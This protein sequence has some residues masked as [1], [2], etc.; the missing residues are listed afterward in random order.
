[1]ILSENYRKNGETMVYTKDKGHITVA[2]VMMGLS[3]TP[4]CSNSTL[5]KEAIDI[6]DKNR[7]GIICISDSSN[8]LEGIITDGDIRRIL[9]RVQKP[10]AAILGDDVVSYAIKN[11]ITV[12]LDTLLIDAVS[13]MG[14]KK[15]WDLPI[16]DNKNGK[17][18]GLLHLHRAIEA[19]LA[20]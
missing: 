1:M 6:M 5:L 8:N 11:P 10:F 18:V 4:R 3:E 2:D 16:L 13:I 15:I 9:T 19:L 12:Y 20:D 14:R 7:L 17:L